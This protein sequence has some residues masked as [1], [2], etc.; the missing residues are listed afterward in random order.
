MRKQPDEC[1][2]KA[3]DEMVQVLGG[4]PGKVI[5]STPIIC[6][7][8]QDEDKEA[9]PY[10]VNDRT[11][12]YW[13]HLCNDCFDNLGCS[14]EDY[15]DFYHLQGDNFNIEAVCP[16]YGQGDYTVFTW[17]RDEDGVAIVSGYDPENAPET[18]WL[19][20]CGHYETGG[21][22]C[23]QCGAEPPWGYDCDLLHDDYDERELME[24]YDGFEPG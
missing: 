17:Y 22:H 20:H 14:Y 24:H 18:D 6:D 7:H 9:F 21:F 15:S 1:L 5:I 19:C 13:H 11:Y 8:C 23:T 16:Y 12:K 4:E 2:V 3:I 10:C